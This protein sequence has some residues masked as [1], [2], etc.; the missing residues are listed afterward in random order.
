MQRLGAHIPGSADTAT[1]II[2]RAELIPYFNSGDMDLEI[3]RALE[4]ITDPDAAGST[5]KAAIFSAGARAG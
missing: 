5:S 2:E 4:K 3:M 1:T